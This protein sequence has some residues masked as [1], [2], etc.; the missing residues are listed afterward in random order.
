MDVIALSIKSVEQQT[1]S[2]SLPRTASVLELKQK[3]QLEFDIDGTRQRLIFQ[4]KVLRDGKN[5]SDYG[6]CTHTQKFIFF[7]L[8]MLYL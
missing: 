2:V 5:L 3:I 8:F 1:K 7:I 4:G 6:K